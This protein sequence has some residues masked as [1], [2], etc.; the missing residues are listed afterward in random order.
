MSHP[1][2]PVD[3]VFLTEERPEQLSNVGA[4]M[5][6]D[7][8]RG[9]RGGFLPRLVEHWRS[10]EPEPPFS[11]VPDILR[12]GR[13]R[14]RA[15]RHLDMSYHVRHVAL[16]A[17]GDDAAL[18]EYVA[19]EH[20]RRMDR[21]RPLFRL[22]VIEGLSGRRFALYLKTHHALIDGQSMACRIFEPLPASPHDA[23]ARPFFASGV[24]RRERKRAGGGLV[25]L[26]GALLGQ[27]GAALDLGRAAL[28]RALAEFG[29]RHAGN[30]PFMAPRTPFNAPVGT[31]RAFAWTTL[32]LETLQ[33][34]ASHHGVTLNDVALAIVD[35]AL[36]RYLGR[37]SEAPERALVAMAPLT[38]RESG[39]TEA[40]TKATAMF[41]P[42]GEPRDDVAARI[43]RIHENTTA[44]K[45]E[46]RGVSKAAALD[47][48]VI[49]FLL[50]RSAEITG[51]S[52]WTAPA[53]NLIMSNV[54]GVAFETRYLGR[55]PLRTALPVSMIATQFGLN[56]TVATYAGA[57]EI[58]LIA[59]RNAVPDAERLAG[60]CRAA[61]DALAGAAGLAPAPAGGQRRRKKTASRRRPATGR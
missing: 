5:I 23:L 38:L 32:P 12:L 17:P 9:D 55:A 31:A 53:A 61:F 42:L 48:A 54:G 19:T 44:A 59:S 20:G 28:R 4:L 35:E 45:A 43:A 24:A 13:P 8:P 3:L 47:Y 60:D 46:L 27:A 36:Q 57:F 14:W 7:L 52:R 29:G 1:I 51:L 41:V 39:D 56:V 25:G 2:N 34:L 21:R 30:R 37:R 15:V 58:G 49:V 26:P 16:P 50:G 18:A 22:H 11:L 33:A 10:F 40:T 6:F